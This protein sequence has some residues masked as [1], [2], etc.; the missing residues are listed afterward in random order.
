M[1]QSY[2]YISMFGDS[3]TC[4]M[5]K[6]KNPTVLIGGYKGVPTNNLAATMY[7][8]SQGPLVV[9]VD[10][11]PWSFYGSGIFNSCKR[12][13]TLNH[14]VVLVG[15]GL[16]GAKGYW[17][18]RNSWGSDWGMN[19]YIKLSRQ[20]TATK[21]TFCGMDYKPQ[22]GSAC[23]GETD[24]VKVCGMCGIL[25]E[26]VLPIVNAVNKPSNFDS[27]IAGVREKKLAITN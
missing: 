21:A 22:E 14:A 8:L 25:Y 16:Q 17:M 10:A 11:S 27:I 15:Y 7:A 3:G 2:Q 19:G 5:E 18:I 12:D 4:D 6:S 24:P 9:A 23:D 20:T 26:P 1:E 13:A